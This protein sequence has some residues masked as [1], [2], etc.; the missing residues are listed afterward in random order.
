MRA[1]LVEEDE[2]YRGCRVPFEY[3]L[4]PAA[5][6]GVGVGVVDW[7]SAS[8]A[9][10][11]AVRASRDG[12][13]M[14]QDGRRI[15]VAITV[16]GVPVETVTRVAA[17]GAHVVVVTTAIASPRAPITLT[18]TYVGARE[19][20]TEV[21]HLVQTT[22]GPRIERRLYRT[23]EVPVCGDDRREC[24][25]V[26]LEML[27]AALAEVGARATVELRPLAPRPLPPSLPQSIFISQKRGTPPA[28]PPS[29]RRRKR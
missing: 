16:D 26:H 14:I 9:G 2:W 19:L 5:V 13:V 12:G 11:R 3:R 17:V 10:R 7:T 21:L 23:D 27:R 24:A 25:H 18:S 15:G 1:F 8:R 4:P 28:E 6:V 20:D 22:Q 29:R